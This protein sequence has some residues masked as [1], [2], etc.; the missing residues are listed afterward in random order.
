M[1]YAC[2]AAGG[3]GGHVMPGLAV[4]HELVAR[5]HDADSIVFVGSERGI[6]T[7]LVPEAGFALEV[8]PGR[9]IERKVSLKA[10]LAIVGIIRGVLRGI[11]LVRRLRPKVIVVCG[12]Y[13]SVPCIVGAVLWRVPMV[14]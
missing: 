7:R 6:E 12:G 4:A 2:I 8:L 5:G 3:T 9:G 1:T 11:F 13:A 14:V 10:L